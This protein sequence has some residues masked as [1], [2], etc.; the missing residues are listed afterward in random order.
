MRLVYAPLL[1]VSAC[2]PKNPN[3][4]LQILYEQA[5]ARYWEDMDRVSMLQAECD[6]LRF[7]FMEQRS[8]SS[9][10]P[11]AQRE[12]LNKDIKELNPWGYIPYDL[13]RCMDEINSYD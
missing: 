7:I 4:D 12:M 2:A 3:L 6:E 11:Y 10:E 5:Q 13:A 1:L 9:I 8:H